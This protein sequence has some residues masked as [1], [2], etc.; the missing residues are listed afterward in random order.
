MPALEVRTMQPD[1]ERF[2]ASCTHVGETDEWDASCR[3]RLPWLHEMGEQGLRVFVALLDGQQAGFLYL[4][5]IEIAPA[6]PVGKD[7]A[8]IQCLTVK[9]G[10]KGQG[11]GRALVAAAER[12]AR[13]SGQKGIVVGAYYH[14]FWFMPASFF[15]ACGYTVAR[16]RDA[17]ALL[18][19]AFDPAAEPPRFM[20][21]RYRFE[22]IEGKVAVD[23]FWSRSCL[24]TDTEAQRVREVAAEYGAAVVLREYSADDP[25]I[26]ERYGI[27]RA[28]FIDGTEV[29]WGYEAPKEGLRAAIREALER[30]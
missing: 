6:G 15:E 17:A 9:E 29:S 7:L 8:V 4:L 22:P 18:W 30:S 27:Y 25:A 21:R 23:L 5:P 26:R 11:A 20:E 10:M 14:D 12:E 2:V 13:T 3:R 16:R 24:T 28:I 19:K 1:D